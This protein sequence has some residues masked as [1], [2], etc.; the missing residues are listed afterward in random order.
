MA[1]RQGQGSTVRPRSSG[2]RTPPRRPSRAER[3]RVFRRRRRTAFALAAGILLLAAWALSAATD[4]DDAGADREAAAPEL[5]R[6]GRVILP[7]YRVVSYYGAPQDD[8]LGVLGTAEPNVVAEQLDERARSYAVRGRPVMPAFELIVTLAQSDP[9][10]DGTYRLRQ[11][12]AV[13][14]RYLQ[15][16][17]RFKGLLILDIQPGHADFLEEVRALEPYL[18]EP[19]VGLALDPEWSTPEGTAPGDEIGSTDAATVNEVSAYLAGLVRNRRLPQKLLILHQFTEEMI[20]DRDQIVSRPGLAIVN[21]ID[22]FGGPEIKVGIYRQLAQ[23]DSPAAAGSPSAAGATVDAGSAAEAGAPAGGEGA[24][25]TGGATGDVLAPPG[26]RS[27]NGL[28]LFF[29]EDT[30]LMAPADVLAIDPSPDVVV[31]E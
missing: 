4:G 13:V 12:R 18:L 5:P 17:R 3:D 9:G 29:R 8:E 21:N 1:A 31:Y 28:K 30:D 11:S 7:R 16:V 27:F 22:G 6:G 2:R 23:Q 20:Q 25:G 14:T 19:D 26:R 10:D 15:A 24:T